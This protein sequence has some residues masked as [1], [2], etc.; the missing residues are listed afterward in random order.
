MLNIVPGPGS[1]VGMALVGIRASTRSFTGSTEVG[2]LIMREAAES[3]KKVT[4]ELGGKSP[5]IVFADADLDAAVRG[6]YNGIFTARA[7]YAR[8]L[9]AARRE[10]R[11][12]DEFV[13]KLVER[14]KKLQPG[15]PPIRRRSGS[16]YNEAQMKKVLSYVETGTRRARSC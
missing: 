2:K 16:A 9:A 11:I 8:G 4:L 14:T 5:N 15:D 1:I 6:A 10:E 13:A 7:R 12:H 3:V